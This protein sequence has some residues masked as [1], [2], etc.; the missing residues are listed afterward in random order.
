M[1]TPPSRIERMEQMN[2]EELVT[3]FAI[4]RTS[5]IHVQENAH[6]IMNLMRTIFHVTSM[7][8]SNHVPLVSIP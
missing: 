6:L 8:M 3:R 7:T 2:G 4:I 5:Y 1:Y